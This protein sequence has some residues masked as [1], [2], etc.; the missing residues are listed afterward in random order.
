MKPEDIILSEIPNSTYWPVDRTSNQSRQF[1][2]AC[3]LEKRAKTFLEIGSGSSAITIDYLLNGDGDETATCVEVATDNYQASLENIQYHSLENRVELLNVLAQDFLDS[4]NEK[5]DAIYIGTTHLP[6][7]VIGRL[8]RKNLK[9]GGHVVCVTREGFI[10]DL[11]IE[12]VKRIYKACRTFEL[13]PH[14]DTDV[15]ELRIFYVGQRL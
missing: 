5:Y 13:I 10:N 11:F 1:I 4:N 7:D 6:S 15:D 2:V 14:L 8:V 12:N 3:L 9:S